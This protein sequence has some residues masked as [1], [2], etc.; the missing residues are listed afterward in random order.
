MAAAPSD[1][2]ARTGSA[3]NEA[4]IRQLA[5]ELRPVRRLRPPGFRAMLW[6]GAVLVLG[7][8]V[9]LTANMQE[10]ERTFMEVPDLRFA[11]IG[12]ALTAVLAAIATFELSLP[13]RSARWMLLPLPGLLIWIG[14][15]GWG[16][17]RSWVAPGMQIATMQEARH[18]VFLILAFS[19]PLSLLLLGM[20]R[21][22]HPLR[23]GPV[24]VLGGLAVSAAA[25]TVLWLVHDYDTAATDLLMHLGAVLLVVLGN[26]AAARVIGGPD[27]PTR[28]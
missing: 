26:A 6:L 12:S 28:R 9:A 15:S 11:M 19:I 4:L 5:A 18:C 24:A 27:R 21:R 1:R 13:D 2:G 3:H 10:F 23:P 25:A 16:C 14:S 17:L 8:L 20:L 7:G 22:A